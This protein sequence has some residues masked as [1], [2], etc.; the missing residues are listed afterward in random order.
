MILTAFIRKHPKIGELENIRSTT[1]YGLKVVLRIPTNNNLL[2]SYF[3]ERYSLL[4]ILNDRRNTLEL[5][6]MGIYLM[7]LPP[8]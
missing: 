6:E 4:L 7:D 8:G 1:S 3:G 5:S 2:I